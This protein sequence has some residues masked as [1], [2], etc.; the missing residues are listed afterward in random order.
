MFKKFIS[1]TLASSLVFLPF[2][3]SSGFAETKKEVNSSFVK[4]SNF[5]T[6]QSKNK[7]VKK[8]EEYVSDELIVKFKKG[9]NSEAVLSKY[10]LQTKKKIKSMGISLVK[11][12]KNQTVKGLMGTLSKDPNVLAVQPNYKYYPH[13]MPNDPYVQELWGLHNIGQS[14]NGVKGKADV[15]INAPEAWELVKNKTLNEVVVAVIDTGVDIN[16]P[17]LKDRIWVNEAEKNGDPGVDDDENGYIDD[18]HGWDFYNDDNTVFDPEDGDEHG[19]HVAGTIAASMN[20]EIGVAGIAPNAKIMPLKFL[21]PD[22]GYTF[23][24][25]EAIEYAKKMGVKI[26]NNSWGGYGGYDGDALEQAIENS[27]MLFIAA[28][29]NETNNNDSNPAYPA[30]YNSAN[31]FSVAAVDNLGRLADFSNF[32]KTSVDIAAPGVDILSTVPSRSITIPRL[33]AASETDAGNYKAIFNG[34]GFEYMEDEAERKDAFSKAMS[35]LEA[36]TSSKILLVDDDESDAGLPSYLSIYKNLLSSLGYKYT[37]LS[38]S[39]KDDGPSLNVLNQYDIVIWFTGDGWGPDD[40]YALTSADESNLV[41]YLENNGKLLLSGQDAIWGNESS[42]LVVDKLGI[43]WVGETFSIDVFGVESTIYAGKEYQVKPAEFADY[44]VS[45]NPEITKINLEYP[46][47]TINFNE[48]EYFSG[49]SM[50]TP[51]VTG[52]AALLMGIKSNSTPAQIIDTL[53]ATGKPLTSLANKTV[54]GK[55]VDIKRALEVYIPLEFEEIKEVYD[56]S[57]YV[58]GK[59]NAVAKVT[60]RVAGKSYTAN[61]D[62]NGNFKVKI[63]YQPVG[64]TLVLK[65]EAG[66]KQSEEM[67]IQVLKDNV[68]PQLESVVASDANPYIEGK[69]NEEAKVQ[70]KVGNILFPK[71]PVNTDVNGKFKVA[72]GKLRAGDKVTLILIDNAKQPNMT[73]TEV[74]VEDK[75]APIIAKVNPVYNTSNFLEGSV[76]ESAKLS[77]NI[78]DSKGNILDTLGTTDTVEGNTFKFELPTKLA[79]GTTVS[80]QATDLAGNKSK[81]FTTKV[82]EDKVPPKLIE[83]KEIIITDKDETTING[84]LSEEGRIEATVNN[85]QIIDPVSTDKDGKFTLTIPKLS[86]NSKVTFT[87]FD[88]GTAKMQK[89]VSVMDVT[90]PVIDK[91]SIKPVFNTSKFIEG[92]VSEPSVVTAEIGGKVVASGKTDADGN[93]KLL[94]NRQPVGTNITL[95]AKDYAKPKPLESEKVSVVVE[96]D[97]EA[98]IIAEESLKLN[99]AS[100][101]LEGKVNEEATIEVRVGDNLI[102]KKPIPTDVNGY[103]KVNVGKLKAGTS[104]TII[105]KDYAGN[106]TTV[107]KTV[108]DKTAPVIEKVNPVYN[109]SNKI[110]GKV[111][112]Q[113]NVTIYLVDT[114]SNNKTELASGQSDEQGNFSIELQNEL[115]IGTKLLVEAT[116]TAGQ[117]SKPFYITVL[118]DTVSPELA[119]PL[120]ITD[121]T[122]DISG[123]LNERGTVQMKLN[124]QL[125][126]EVET[127]ENNAF[128]IHLQEPFAAGT[129]VTF[130]LIDKAGNQKSFVKT[131]QKADILTSYS[132]LRQWIYDEIF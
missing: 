50:A 5:S 101:Y 94:I 123:V 104:V 37:T 100:P 131:V 51:H 85:E 56:S 108:E 124:N 98:P 57:Q 86:A 113:A 20:N 11:L 16:H 15:D 71:T 31:I 12:K 116:D 78:V 36:S 125:I 119:I 63:G 69:V 49:T 17:D 73:E 122:I 14:I 54:S 109:T 4:T 42:E 6:L 127:D 118:K 120:E 30:S 52:A 91:A 96:E 46:E 39:Q 2:L 58:E 47:Q 129:K 59:V 9:V 76:S 43:E 62:K 3:S 32:G 10:G 88:T 126:S 19:T 26:S 90:Q 115:A 112:E 33:G 8:K 23:D 95:T 25:I 82:L 130:V 107:T 117:V 81:I 80:I 22:G 102:T 13:S 28:A 75:T 132:L 60:V 68:P 53:K 111:S 77:I 84:Q 29:G 55:M 44:I 27:G 64:T 34:F 128:T 74:T 66:T 114:K 1:A 72:T 70:V 93:F 48:Y 121:Q 35:F 99:D 110:S 106:E 40:D 65:A 105:A 67:N 97:T 7:K 89:V 79:K 21:G 41:Q 92:K 103:F 83:P 45:L 87:F 24:A 18:I 38:V 61:T